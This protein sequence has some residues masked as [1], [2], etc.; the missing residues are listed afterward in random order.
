MKKIWALTVCTLLCAALAAGCFTPNTQG[1]GALPGD[2]ATSAPGGNIPSKTAGDFSLFDTTPSAQ[3]AAPATTAA[4]KTAQPKPTKKP[5]QSPAP[6]P[7]PE[8]LSGNRENIPKSELLAF[9]NEVAI[10]L[11]SQD[12]SV[13]KWTKPIVVS[14]SGNYTV[15]D[16]AQ[17]TS[18]FDMLNDYDGFPGVT[19]LGAAGK[20]AKANL[21]VKFLSV[22]QMKQEVTDWDGKD[23]CYAGFHDSKCAIQDGTIYLCTEMATSQAQRNLLLTWGVFY[24]IGLYHESSMYYDSIFN[25]NYDYSKDSEY[26]NPAAADWYMVSYLYR[27]SVK[28]DMTYDQAAAA[29]GG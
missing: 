27:K 24:T 19:Y 23:R 22:D 2:D 9:F 13:Y 5:V 25:V 11:E 14:L 21:E 10:G 18:I 28:P 16:E 6:T 4:A 8:S 15:T 20:G 29:L 1:S 7:A 12:Q 17:L 3:S 26:L